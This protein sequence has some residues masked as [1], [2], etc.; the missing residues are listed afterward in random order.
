[1]S[2]TAIPGGGRGDDWVELGAVDGADGERIGLE[3]PGSGEPLA[4]IARA[5][6]VDVDRA[7]DAARACVSDRRL[8]DVKP[9]ERGRWLVAMSDWLEDHRSEVAEVLARDSGKTL[10]EANWEVDNATTFLT[11]YGGL[12]DKIEGRYIPLGGSRNGSAAT[13]RNLATVFFLTALWH[14]AAWT[15]LVWGGLHGLWLIV[16]RVTGLGSTDRLPIVR[17]GL[18]LLIVMVA[19]VCFLV[20]KAYNNWKKDDEEDSGPTEID[21]LT[22]IRDSLQNR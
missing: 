21:L 8:V 22:E 20:V 6:D 4:E 19:W 10:T 18:T 14:G 9:A 16:E 5:T 1:M 15:F 12:A 13:Y 11:Y 7:V 2:G 17:R 3:D